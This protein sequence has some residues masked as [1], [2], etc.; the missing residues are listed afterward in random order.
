M[1]ESLPTIDSEHHHRL[2]TVRDH[3]PG[4][5]ATHLAVARWLRHFTRLDFESKLH[6]VK[7]GLRAN[8]W[9][10]IITA[11]DTLQAS[12]S[13]FVPLADAVLIGECRRSAL[14]SHRSLHRLA[15]S[16]GS[17]LWHFIPKHHMLDNVFRKCSNLHGARFNPASIGASLMKRLLENVLS[18]APNS[19]L[20]GKR[21]AL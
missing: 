14:N 8:F 19:T 13:F 18:S 5:A 11:V 12:P 17:L 10:V 9:W 20:F 15:R 16:E 3:W 7:A 2:A 21:S 6:Q 4:K 1:G